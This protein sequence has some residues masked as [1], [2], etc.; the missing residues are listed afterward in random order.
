[1]A[2][3]FLSND[4]DRQIERAE[5]GQPLV[6]DGRMCILKSKSRIFI[7]GF[8]LYEN[9]VIEDTVKRKREYKNR[10]EYYFF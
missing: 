5:I 1:M 8:I 4:M 7:K 10:G 6:V 9:R 2:Q 3:I